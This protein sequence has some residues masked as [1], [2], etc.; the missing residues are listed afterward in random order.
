MANRMEWIA[1]F[2]RCP[3]L[4]RVLANRVAVK[5]V[6]S[7]INERAL[8]QF[9]RHQKLAAARR[10]AILTQCDHRHVVAICERVVKFLCGIPKTMPVPVA[11]KRCDADE[12]A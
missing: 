6:V 11:R 8:L 4:S 5:Q 10:R 12:M 2:F 3:G 1:D 7:G 9:A